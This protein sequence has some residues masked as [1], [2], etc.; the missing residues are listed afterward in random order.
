MNKTS[1]YDNR[2]A[3]PSFVFHHI[4]PDQIGAVAALHGVTQSDIAHCRVLELGCGDGANLLSIAYAMPDSTCVGID[5]SQ[6]RINEANANAQ[7]IGITNAIFRAMDV[8]D[9]SPEEFGEFDF[10]IAHGLYSWVPEPVREHILSIYS[11][12]LKPGG[13]GYISY[14]AY[15]GW[16]MRNAL[17]DAMR[18]QSENIADPIEKLDSS[19]NFVQFLC[20]TSKPGSVYRAFLEDE[21]KSFSARYKA[22]LLHDDLN[23]VNQPFYFRDFIET[24]S[25]HRLKFVSESEP[26]AFFDNPLPHFAR[27]LLEQLWD[28]PIRREQYLDFIRCARFRSTLVCHNSADPCYR[29]NV[30]AVET[31]FLSTRSDPKSENPVFT[32]DSEVTFTAPHDTEFS[33]NHPFTKTALEVLSSSRPV[34]LTFNELA[35]RVTDSFPD[36][37]KTTLAAERDQLKA[38]VLELIHSSIVEA[39]CFLPKFVHEVSNLPRMSEFARWQAETGFEYATS[40]TGTSLTIANDLVRAMIVLL[41]GSRSRDQLI[42]DLLEQVSVPPDERGSFE[43]ALPQLVDTNL[44]TFVKTALLIA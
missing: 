15:P 4:R 38:Y 30:D 13:V 10:I 44:K 29:P 6:D 18:F 42:A 39:K 5:L 40:L 27:E 12:S 24:I 34:R 41:D 19:L 25:K 3:Y 35:E 28:D 9:F 32:D 33:T 37:D 8:M 1:T 26:V 22:S 2:V 43:S 17:R 23:D 7:R 16:H 21:R 14:N 11:S 31:F 20:E 36:L